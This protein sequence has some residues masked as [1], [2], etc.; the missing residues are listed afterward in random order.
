M[1]PNKLNNKILP[2]KIIRPLKK[3]QIDIL[4]YF[5]KILEQDKNEA[6]KIFKKADLQ[7]VKLVKI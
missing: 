4:Q 7:K 1:K 2:I 5:L 6:M 3:A